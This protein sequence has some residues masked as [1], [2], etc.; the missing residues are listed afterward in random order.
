MISPILFG[1][2]NSLESAVYASDKMEVAP[3]LSVQGGVRY[4]YYASI[5]PGN[6]YT[7]HQ[8]F[9]RDIRYIKDTITFTGRSV[10]NSSHEPDLRVALNFITDPDGSI[11]LSFNQ[12]HQNIFV[13]NNTI[14]LSPDAQWKLSDYH[15]KPANSNQVSA[16]IFRVFARYGMEASFETYYKK[17][18]NNPEFLDGADILGNPLV[19]TSLLQGVQEAYGFEF[20]LKRNNQ[21]LE[22]WLSYTYSRS[23]VRVD[24]SDSW[25]KINNGNTYPAN[26]DIP[27]VLNAV[28]NYHI[29]RRLTTSLVLAYQSGK[30]VTY[31]V[32]IYYLNGLPYVEYSARNSYRIPDYFRI[33][34]SLAVEGNLKRKKPL[35]NSFIFGVYNLTGRQNVYSVYFRAED[36]KVRSYRY[37]VIGVPIFTITWSFK[38]G[39]YAAG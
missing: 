13:L 2:E 22:G 4:A 8:G 12:L 9:P 33:D 29:S 19:E 32:S 38:L 28:M 10:M 20:L 1:I 24:G 25:A 7:Y 27:H 15:L 21:R 17:T 36:G 34:L 35:H 3:W 23:L 30:P 14:A 11:K 18:Y 31:P 6:V 26:Y 39:N 16:G 37:S 5:G